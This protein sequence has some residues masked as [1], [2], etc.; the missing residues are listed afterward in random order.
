MT[1]TMPRFTVEPREVR[2]AV[3]VLAFALA[4]ASL[5]GA[6]GGCRGDGGG[7]SAAASA[8]EATTGT[9]TTSLHATR[10]GMKHFY[11]KENGGFELLSGVP[12]EQLACAK[13]HGPTYADGTP[14]D[15]ATYEASCRDCHA[16]PDAPGAQKVADATCLA[17]HSR[18]KAEIAALPDVHRA[19]G[20]GCT[21][22]HTQREMHGDGASYDSMLSGAMDAKC[23]SC[24]PERDLAKGNRFHSLHKDGV[25][26]SACHVR[27]VV[28]C[29]SCH[30]QSELAGNKRYFS[31]PR[32][33]FKMLT[34]WN[35]KV[36][37]A[38]FQAITTDDKTFYAIAPYMAHSITRNATLTC[39]D[40][41]RQGGRHLEEEEIAGGT[42]DGTGEDSATAGNAAVDE[43]ARTGL[44]TV[45][46]WDSSATGTARLVGPKGVIPVPPDWTG[47]LVF[48]HLTYLGDP[49][50]PLTQ[51]D[52][53][54]W[55]F[56][57][58]ETDLTHMPFGEGLSQ[59]QMD[60]LMY[61]GN[62]PK[63]GR[64]KGG[65]GAG[66]GGQGHG[67]QGGH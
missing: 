21:E 55:D 16:N 9:F 37:S 67:P 25:D 14:V 12:Y 18:Q 24:H 59:K 36:T 29:T 10:A 38:T 51:T 40:C 65:R 8:I 33:G 49:R 35:G 63:A 39:G 41:H 58:S 53:A 4:A 1:T 66:G 2:G 30:F 31:P 11:S 26:C 34:Q 13:C 3:R 27:S 28:A 64:G 20:M 42:H 54:L 23:E 6:V 32:T 57:K 19:A 43:Y 50:T 5:I 61:L 46:R 62:Q 22:C 60:A 56:L 52:P 17:C 45:Q 15:N 48:D 44:I 47:A 7:A